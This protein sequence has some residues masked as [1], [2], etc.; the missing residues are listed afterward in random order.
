MVFLR[1]PLKGPDG[2]RLALIERKIDHR[3]HFVRDGIPRYAHSLF[4]GNI[5]TGYWDYLELTTCKKTPSPSRD[6]DLPLGSLNLQCLLQL[7][8]LRRVPEVLPE[9]RV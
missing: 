9:L 7:P 6:R 4:D 8:A 2:D 5:M 3:F 1:D